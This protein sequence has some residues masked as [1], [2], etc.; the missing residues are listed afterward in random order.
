MLSLS[1]PH[2]HP[3]LFS[4]LLLL[5]E[6]RE[7]GRSSIVSDHPLWNQASYTRYQHTASLYLPNLGGTNSKVPVSIRK[8]SLSRVLVPTGGC[9]LSS[10]I[11]LY[12]KPVYFYTFVFGIPSRSPRTTFCGAAC[13]WFPCYN[14]R[15]QPWPWWGLVQDAVK[16]K[17]SLTARWFW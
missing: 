15:K 3:K 12:Q 10:S 8:P 14:C 7:G 4:P 5:V 16:W 2:Y 1:P 17:K 11:G 9:V 13:R 6:E